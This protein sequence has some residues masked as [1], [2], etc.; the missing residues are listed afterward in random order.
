MVTD[1]VKLLDKNLVSSGHCYAKG[2]RV[3]HG[4]YYNFVRSDRKGN[5]YRKATV[6]DSVTPV[7]SV[8]YVGI[9]LEEIRNLYLL[10]HKDHEDIMCWL[11]V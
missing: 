9:E 6:M 11:Y 2:I 7:E 4:Y 10:D 3:V 5:Y 1:E 8:L